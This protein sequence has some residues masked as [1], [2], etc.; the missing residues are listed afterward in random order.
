MQYKT[1]II[2]Q[3]LIFLMIL[4]TPAAAYTDPGSGLMLWQILGAAAVGS[5][6]YVKRFLSWFRRK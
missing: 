1:R 6:F 3:V 5:L 4:V 2:P